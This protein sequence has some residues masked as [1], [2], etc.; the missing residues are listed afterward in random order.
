MMPDGQIIRALSG[1]YYVK[2][3]DGE[4]VQCRARGKFKFGKRK[5]APL[6]GDQVQIDQ[7]GLGEGVITFIQP[8]STELKR[9]PIANVEQAVIVCSLC[10]PDFSQMPL[11]RFLVQAERMDLAIVICLTKRDLL[12]DDQ[13]IERIRAIYEPAGYPLIVMSRLDDAGLVELRQRLQE[14]VSVFAGQSGVGKSTLL[15][16][17]LP[18]VALATGAVSQKI[19]RGRHTTREVELLSLDGG[20]QVAD[21]PGF[22]QLAFDDVEEMELSDAFPEFA[23]PMTRCRYRGCLHDQE[24]DCGVKEAVEAGEIALTRHQYY[25][26]FLQEIKNKRRY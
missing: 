2:T 23:E 26:H 24:T 25:L 22:S 16:R 15:N 14:K 17:L 20:G 8:R 5:Q 1:F 19:G 10:E 11:D 21:T 12:A 4:T 18:G 13:E 7:T 6:V 3:A 9:P